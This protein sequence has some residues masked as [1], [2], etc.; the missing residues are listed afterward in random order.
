M[1]VQEGTAVCLCSFNQEPFTLLSSPG[2]RT[3]VRGG[4]PAKGR[5]RRR[6]C[7]REIWNKYDGKEAMRSPQGRAGTAG[8][9]IR[10]KKTRR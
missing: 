9:L 2:L 1:R 3:R 8:R 7:R 4:D 10:D 5:G 6:R